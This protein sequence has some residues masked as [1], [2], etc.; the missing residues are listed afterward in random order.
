MEREFIKKMIGETRPSVVRAEMYANPLTRAM[1][2]VRQ[3]A[4]DGYHKDLTR[5][6]NDPF[7]TEEQLC[8]GSTKAHAR[9]AKTLEKLVPLR[10]RYEREVQL[11][12]LVNSGMLKKSAA[13]SLRRK[14][15]IPAPKRNRA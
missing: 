6:Y 1:E 15:G 14:F 7:L 10:E 12:G 4:K 3:E 9:W 11:P 5:L 2:M 13:A 8:V